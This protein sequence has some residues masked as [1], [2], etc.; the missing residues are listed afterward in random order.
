M[1]CACE[2]LPVYTYY[3]TDRGLSLKLRLFVV[4]VA[5]SSWRE[6][7]R[8]EICGTHWR[9]DIPDKF[10]QQFAW[11]VGDFREDWATVEFVDEQKALLLQRRGGETDEK[12]V[13]MSC[14]K[15]RVKGMAF[16]IDHL[17]AT[18]ARR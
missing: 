9:I 5:E 15:K 12:C 6:L 16:C 10:Q 7:F 13:W 18:G 1:H 11:K 2:E 8:C 4:R 14:E 17:Y 3:H